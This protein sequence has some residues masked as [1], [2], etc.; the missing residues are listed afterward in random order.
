MAAVEVIV[1]LRL[2]RRWRYL[3]CDGKRGGD[4]G[5]DGGSGGDGGCGD[6]SREGGEEGS[7]E[8]AVDRAVAIAEMN[9]TAAAMAH[10][11]AAQMW[12]CDC[13]CDCGGARIGGREASRPWPSLDRDRAWRAA[14]RGGPDPSLTEEDYP[15]LLASIDAR[16]RAKH[17]QEDRP[18]PDHR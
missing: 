17:R 2:W 10:A 12:R 6:C 5:G 18:S 14:S 16:S 1:A 4:R 3:E 15:K 11:M 8:R 13:K 9:M 7:V